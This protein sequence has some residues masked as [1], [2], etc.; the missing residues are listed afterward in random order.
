MSGFIQ[1]LSSSANAILTLEG[2]NTTCADVFYVWVCIAYHLEQ[3]LASPDVGVNHLRD[4]VIGI[5]NHRFHQMMEESSHNIFLLS[6]YLHPCTFW[7]FKLLTWKV[8]SNKI[9]SVPPSWRVTIDD[10][11]SCGWTESPSRSISIAFQATPYI[12]I[13]HFPRRA[14]AYPWLWFRGCPSAD[15]GVYI[16]CVQ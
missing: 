7:Q 9:W 5:Y 10:V 4:N 2:Q 11:H 1:L 8:N 12:C 15:P 13:N 3:I 6:Y 16:L 14:D